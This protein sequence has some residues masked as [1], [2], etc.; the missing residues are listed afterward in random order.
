M[1]SERKQKTGFRVC[2]EGSTGVRIQLPGIYY[3]IPLCRSLGGFCSLGVRKGCGS[4]AADGGERRKERTGRL[5]GVAVRLRFV[6][7]GSLQFSFFFFVMGLSFT[8]LFFLFVVCVVHFTTRVSR[9]CVCR[10][11]FFFRSKRPDWT[12]AFTSF[13]PFFSVLLGRIKS[14]VFC[15]DRPLSERTHAASSPVGTACL[16][17]FVNHA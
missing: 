5:V 4:S 14:V 7:F 2:F 13:N 10:S 9:I 16:Q 11:S 15:Q 3:L 1:S 6:R 17:L 8:T 12:G